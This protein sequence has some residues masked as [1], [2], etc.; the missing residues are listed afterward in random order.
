[1]NVLCARERARE[2]LGERDRERE[3][4]SMGRRERARE[5]ARDGERGNDRKRERE[6][7]PYV[8]YPTRR[9]KSNC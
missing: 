6:T 4:D 8:P 1:M 5:K 3:R 9:K 7:S 2:G